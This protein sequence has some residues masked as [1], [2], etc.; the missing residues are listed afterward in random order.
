MIGSAKERNGLYYLDTEEGGKVQAYQTKGTAEGFFESYWLMHE[1]LGYP[2]F[3]Y[4]QQLYPKLCINL[5]NSKLKC[6]VCE[7]AKNHRIRIL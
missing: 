4:L 3:A 1:R 5:D 7:L 2:I 6:E